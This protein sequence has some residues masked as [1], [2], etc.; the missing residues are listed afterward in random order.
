MRPIFCIRSSSVK[1]FPI[2]CF[3]F[4][5][6]HEDF[7]CAIWSVG[8]CSAPASDNP[9]HLH[10]SNLRNLSNQRGMMHF[11]CSNVA[12]CVDRHP[13]EGTVY[14]LSSSSS[15]FAGKPLVRQL[16]RAIEPFSQNGDIILR[17]EIFVFKLSG[18]IEG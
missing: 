6:V 12:S 15:S 4:R 8:F 9:T 2:L 5:G 18:N 11:Y 13:S 7:R 17:S 10:L 14:M 3:P 1:S 16:P